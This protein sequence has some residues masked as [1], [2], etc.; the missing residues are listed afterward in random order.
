[1]S[2]RSSLIDRELASKT[3]TTNPRASIIEE[4]APII[5]RKSLKRNSIHDTRSTLT[6]PAK[7][8]RTSILITPPQNALVDDEHISMSR[9]QSRNYSNLMPL[10]SRQD[11]SMESINQI[12]R[13]LSASFLPEDDVEGIICI[14]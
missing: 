6:S 10:E 9:R 8:S 1:M 12:H 3:K 4:D 7:D 2:R 5:H 14:R 11:N 13:I